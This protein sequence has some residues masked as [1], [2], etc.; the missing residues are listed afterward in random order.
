MDLRRNTVSI[1]AG[2]HFTDK[3]SAKTSVTYM[4]AAAV[5]A[6]VWDMELKTLCIPSPGLVVK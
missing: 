2:Y 4:N 5:I 6:Q 3:F 1:N